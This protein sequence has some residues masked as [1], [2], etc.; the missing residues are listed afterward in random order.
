MGA[1]QENREFGPVRERAV[2]SD[3]HAPLAVGTLDD[4]L[5]CKASRVDRIASDEP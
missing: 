2:P 1:R 4:L 5:V 3:D